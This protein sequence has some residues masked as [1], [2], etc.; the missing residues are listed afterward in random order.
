MVYLQKKDTGKR[1]PPKITDGDAEDN[2]RWF[3]MSKNKTITCN[4]KQILYVR[5]K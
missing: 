3:K 1:W 4:G 5:C 2:R